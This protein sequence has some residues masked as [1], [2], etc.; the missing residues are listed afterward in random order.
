MPDLTGTPKKLLLPLLLRQDISVTMKGS[1]FVVHQDPP[2]GTKVEPG[3]KIIL[4]L[5]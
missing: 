2:P 4:E 3:M 1:G 5:Q